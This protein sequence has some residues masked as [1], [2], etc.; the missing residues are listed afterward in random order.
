MNEKPSKMTL[1][2]RQDIAKL[3]AMIAERDQYEYYRGIRKEPPLS[4]LE[5]LT[6][7]IIG[8]CF[9]MVV[10]EIIAV[11]FPK[12]RTDQYDTL[13]M[14]YIRQESALNYKNL[15]PTAV[16][17][18]T[19]IQYMKVGQYGYTLAWF[20]SPM[21]PVYASREGTADM[22]IH[23]I[24]DTEYAVGVS[25]LNAKKVSGIYDSQ[26]HYIRGL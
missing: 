25:S 19:T 13:D 24:S 26:G 4:C 18:E 23:R 21:Y 12:K 11:S 15:A 1:I 17:S 8:I 3:D 10:A 2:H 5:I 20:F 9:W 16:L 6:A 14:P 7:I 22:Y